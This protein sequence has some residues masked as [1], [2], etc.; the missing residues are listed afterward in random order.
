MQTPSRKR[1]P[2]RVLPPALMNQI[3]AGEV[4]ERPS[5]VVKELVENALDAGASRV[6]VRV[7]RGGAGRIVVAD[8]GHGI[9]P[10]ELE[11]AVTRHATSKLADA[12]GLSAI[13]S[14][15]FRGE[16]L[17]SIASVSRLTVTSSFE[18][19]DAQF[20]RVHSGETM[21]SGPAALARGTRVEV[22]DLFVSVPA[23]LKFLKTEATEARRCQETLMRIALANPEAAFTFTS[24]ERTLFSLPRRQSLAD[25]L[26]AFWPPAV[27]AGLLP[28]EYA[29]T[30][31]EATA[32][33]TTGHE[34]TGHEAG[35]YE[36]RGLVGSP[37]SAQARGDR[38]LLFV[39]GRPVQDRLLLAA[40]R[41]AY[42][43]RLL[44]KEHP[45]AVLF[46]TLDPAL[47]D[48]N[49]HP[50][51]MEVRFSDES[52]VFRLVRSGVSRALAGL[53]LGP[54]TQGSVGAALYDGGATPSGSGSALGESASAYGPA[55][56]GDMD[57]M[58]YAGNVNDGPPRSAS[59]GGRHAPARPS[60]G[61]MYNEKYRGYREFSAGPGTLP[62]EPGQPAPSGDARQSPSSATAVRATR[63]PRSL[64]GFDYLGQ[65]ADTYLV[66]RRGADLFLVD[67]HA[68]H[69][70]ILLAA[71]RTQRTK[72]DSQP[73]AVPLELA[74]HPSEAERFQDVREELARAG[75]RLRTPGAGALLVEGI[76]PTLDAGRAREYL[77]AVLSGQADEEAG[78]RGGGLDALWTM[79]CCKSAIKAGTPLAD[80]EALSLLEAW[81]ACPERD[82]CP[83]GRPIVV[84]FSPNDLEKLFKRK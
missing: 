68:A 13:R 66:L 25:R 64:G 9:P 30:E 10:G 84:S 35:G 4:V 55:G 29:I 15:G 61:P 50:A 11:L 47:V 52:A 14:F 73:L 23:R 42:T 77:R 70:R 56:A 7:E 43:G 51:K 3:A 41:Q 58:G 45:Q 46:V 8:D 18:G 36:M 74:L 48:V 37:S 27:C 19:A 39:N 65:V 12:A 63:A 67:Q 59:S 83:H 53:D 54:G 28:V 44:S 75:F 79:L 6:E 38:I 80:D 57:N 5:S 20:V 31:H 17:P 16:A 21:E 69:E 26:G 60:S 62:L 49:V 82:Y 81:L 76:P 78:V 2:I 71:M 40:L 72:G 33:E 34:T 22:E 1:A 24:G 32:D